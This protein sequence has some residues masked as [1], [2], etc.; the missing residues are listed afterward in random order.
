MNRPT[1][2][3]DLPVGDTPDWETGN[4]LQEGVEL[5]GVAESKG[6]VAS[7]IVSKVF[8]SL[9]RR[10]AAR[11]RA[12]AS[13][14]VPSSATFV[15]QSA[16]SGSW[17]LGAQSKPSTPSAQANDVATTAL[18]AS[19]SGHTTPLLA[20]LPSTLHVTQTLV[21]QVNQAAASN[22][23]L[24]NLL[25][26]AVAG[27]ASADQLKT[28]GLL[29][30]S[31]AD[32]PATEA[33]VAQSSTGPA[34]PKAQPDPNTTT[35]PAAPQYQLQP[36]REF[37]LVL[38]FKEV[39][40]DRWTFP[41]GPAKCEFI[42]MPGFS[43]AFGD[44]LLTTVL[45]FTSAS[46]QPGTIG[47][48]ATSEAQSVA[49]RIVTFRFKSASTAVWDTVSR[50]I[51]SQAEEY[52]KILSEIKP[53]DRKFLAHRLSEGAELSQIQNAAVPSFSMK[54]IKPAG[55]NKN[56]RKPSRKSLADGDHPTSSA[57]KRKRNTQNKSQAVH[58]KMACF[59][60]GQTDVPLTNGGRYCRPCVNDGRACEPSP[61]VH[62]T[63]EDGQSKGE[64]KQDIPPSTS[65]P[66]TAAKNP[67][68]TNNNDE[69]A[70]DDPSV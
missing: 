27:K 12:P 23:T 38:E 70:I 62:L 61:A 11:G 10:K 36:P 16:P 47:S 51:G 53:P 8:D 13:Y 32:S 35:A 45:P 59:S 14:T 17:Q 31:L 58:P 24:A 69:D 18:P 63:T 64:S 54:P 68:A 5:K 37:D 56:K 4:N 50:W 40:T 2:V 49:K 30:Q 48:E 21:T 22:P 33:N 3:L 15:Y 26:L 28:L 6:K 19:V 65:G 46:A 1:Q 25:Q 42:S 39:P 9:K 43:G 34:Q 29:I 44:V 60:C 67:P 52:C 41:R 55:E 20:S 7:V 66:E 57:T